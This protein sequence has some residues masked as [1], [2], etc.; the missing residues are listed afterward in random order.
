ML[1]SLCGTWGL[2][3]FLYRTPQTRE[4][5]VRILRPEPLCTGRGFPSPFW[6]VGRG[7][8]AEATRTTGVGIHVSL[9]GGHTPVSSPT[10]LPS[11]FFQGLSTFQILTKQGG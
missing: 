9:S 7:P 4:L 2:C 5:L 11:F 3:E 10:N 6:S 1:V 8:K